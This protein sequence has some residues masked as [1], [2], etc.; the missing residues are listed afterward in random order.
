ME[1]EAKFI[2]KEGVEEKLREIAEPVIEKFEHDIYFNHPCKDFKKTDEAVRIRRDVEG[3]TVTY[4]G[5]KVDLETK[6]REEVKV[7]VDSFENAFELLQKLGFRP[8]REVKKLR[9]IYRLKGAI[10][11][12]DDVEGVGRF[13]EIEIESGSI[14]D[15]EILFDIAKLLG[16]SREESIT[17][18]Y[19]EMILQEK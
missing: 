19:L 14:R 11:C 8:V 9:K 12:V 7:K 5:P 1:V 2:Y 13:I 6:S 17:Q 3:V 4:K 18:S 15:K 10:V 16:Y